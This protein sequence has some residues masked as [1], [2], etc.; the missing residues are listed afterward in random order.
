M[1]YSKKIIRVALAA[2]FGL[3]AVKA[4]AAAQEIKLSVLAPEGSTWVNVMKEMDKELQTASGGKLAFKIYA[5][6]VSGDEKDVIRK[7]RIGQI[8]AAGLTGVGLGDIVPSVR[9]LELPMLFK[10]YQEADYVK[11]KLQK[12]FE[13]QFDQKGYVLLGWAEAGFVNIFSNK[14]IKSKADM[15]GTKWWAWEG[16]PMVKVMYENLGIVPTPL[17]LPDVLTSLQT[18]LIDAVYGPPLGVIALQWF[19]KTKYMTDLNLANST[20]ALIMTKGEFA[21]LA[22][23]LQNTLKTTAAKYSDKLIKA[24]R[25]DNAKSIETLKKNGIQ[26]V[27]VEPANKAELE[28]SSLE[29]RPKLVGK[30]YSQD[31]L[32]KVQG[33]IDEY[34]KT[35]AS[36]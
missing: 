6:G 4:Q 15:A 21:K 5:G 31:L 30:L 25:T 34:R 19:T 10:N 11:S 23:D 1:K 8:H 35:H 27:A 32:N 33:F 9:I 7:M 26:V 18:N 2:F 13:T 36:N 17:A 3:A 24:I 14:P 16:D 29:V 20:G 28:K 12:D 22:P